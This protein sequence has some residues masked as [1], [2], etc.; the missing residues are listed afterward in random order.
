[1]TGEEAVKSEDDVM[2]D[3]RK[4]LRKEGKTRSQGADQFVTSPEMENFED[5]LER[6]GKSIY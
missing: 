6:A 1:M 3:L 5:F 4:R 2:R